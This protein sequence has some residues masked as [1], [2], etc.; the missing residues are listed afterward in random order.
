MLYQTAVNRHLAEL[1]RQ[2][3]GMATNLNQLAHQANAT[4]RI[5]EL[6][7]LEQPALVSGLLPR[8]VN[9]GL[10]PYTGEVK[11]EPSIYCFNNSRP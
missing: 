11:P 3:R 2:I 7:E 4:R 1:V 9:N 10:R 6:Y 8:L 5:P